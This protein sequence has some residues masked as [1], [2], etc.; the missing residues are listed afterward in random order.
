MDTFD[1]S[2]VIFQVTENIQDLIY[3]V[4]DQYQ[5]WVP[6]PKNKNPPINFIGKPTYIHKQLINFVC[7]QEPPGLGKRGWR[8]PWDQDEVMLCGSASAPI[9]QLFNFQLEKFKTTFATT[10]GGR[11]LGIK[12]TKEGLTYIPAPRLHSK[13]SPE[14]KG[15]VKALKQKVREWLVGEVKKVDPASGLTFKTF[16][17]ETVDLLK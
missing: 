5:I 8:A 9:T 11:W 13:D 6:S 2:L 15:E 17:V 4:Q 14:F 16:G 10:W 12:D 1:P 7:G 3:I